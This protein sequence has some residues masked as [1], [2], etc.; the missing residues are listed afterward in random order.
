MSLQFLIGAIIGSGVMLTIARA[1]AHRA[2]ARVKARLGA[3]R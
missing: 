2:L 1:P 3:R